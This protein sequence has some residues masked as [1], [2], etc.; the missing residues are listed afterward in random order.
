MDFKESEQAAEV[1]EEVIAK[2]NKL[3]YQKNEMDDTPHY[4][5]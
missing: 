5:P 2:T 3:E 4:K 1:I